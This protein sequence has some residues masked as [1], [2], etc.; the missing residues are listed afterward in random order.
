MKNLIIITL[1]F[2][3]FLQENYAQPSVFQLPFEK[4]NTF[5]NLDLILD[6]EN[7]AK[8]YYNPEVFLTN[9]NLNNEAVNEIRSTII[10]EDRKAEDIK[11]LISDFKSNYLCEEEG[12]VVGAIE[13]DVIY[14][15]YDSR[16]TAGL[17]FNTLSLG[18]GNLLGIPNHVSVT[19]LEID[20]I[21]LDADRNIVAKYRTGAKKR[22][23]KGLYYRELDQ[24]DTNLLAAGEA[25]EVLYSMMMKDYDIILTGL[26]R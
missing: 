15:D 8:A 23:Y 9:E 17:V 2:L 1:V 21:I 24:R 11:Q 4:Q 12:A 13:F 16:P 22:A 6:H 5:P 26:D 20:V 19:R 10:F 7:L 3:S 18:I 25:L 14:Y